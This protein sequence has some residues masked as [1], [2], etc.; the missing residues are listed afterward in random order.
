[1]IVGWEELAG[2]AGKVAMVDGGFDP[3]HDGH[4]AY[5]TE[6]AGLGAPVLCNVSSD[7]WVSRKHPPLLR[8]EQRGRIIDALRPVAYTHLSQ[9][10]TVEV[11]ERLRPRFYVKGVDWRDSLPE[12]ESGL[13]ASLGIEIVYLDTVLSSSTRLVEDLVRRSSG[14]SA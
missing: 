10:T 7:E 13:C 8:Q 5:F 1:V 9:S 14:V 4:V 11:L 6:A 3:L 2:L 12:E